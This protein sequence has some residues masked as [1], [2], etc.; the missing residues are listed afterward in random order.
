MSA[1]PEKALAGLRI[2]DLSWAIVGNTCTKLLG[3]FGAQV[4]KV[5]SQRRLGLERLLPT[6]AVSRP[7]NPDDKPWFAHVATSK[8]SIRLDLTRPDARPVIETLIQWADVVVENFSPG[9]LDRLDLGYDAMRAIN[10]RIILASGSVYGQTGPYAESW[11]IDG[12]GA[13]LSGRMF[14]TG[15]PDRGPVL[16]S[17][18]YGDC[19]L[20]YLLAA[21]L[22]AAVDERDRSGFGCRIDGS[23]FEVLAQQM[24]PALS[25]GEEVVE[26]GRNGNRRPDAAPHGA[27]PTLGDDRWIAIAVEDDAE[28]AALSD[29]LKQPDWASDPRFASHADRKTNEDILEALIAERTR[30]WVDHDLMHALQARGVAAGVVQSIRDV[31]E[32]PQLGHLDALVEVAHPILGPFAHQSSP[33]GL[34]ATPKAMTPAPRLG[35]HTAIVAR[36]V[37]GMDDAAIALATEERLFF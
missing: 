22:V 21:A 27:F 26:L 36:D 16:T 9:T 37:L 24:L 28:W 13:A 6:V 15:W 29:V 34:S 17:A 10:P 25:G 7:D 12:T 35:E 11:G 20:P 30:T 4:I 23:M 3:D 18:P 32:D 8:Q 19:V 31:L 14:A 5:E 1:P 2:L 33:I